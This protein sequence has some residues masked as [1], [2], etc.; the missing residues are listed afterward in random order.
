MLTFLCYSSYHLS[1]KPI[2]IVKVSSSHSQRACGDPYV[3]Q[4]PHF[5]PFLTS[6]SQLHP[7]CSA[8]GP[9]PHNDS[10]SSTWCSWAPFGKAQIPYKSPHKLPSWQPSQAH[11]CP[12]PGRGSLGTGGN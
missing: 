8:L 4:H 12:E 2:S 6:Q 1:R 11:L 9:N 3:P 7:N 5:T 10:N